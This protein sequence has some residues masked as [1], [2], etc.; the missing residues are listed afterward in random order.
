MNKRGISALIAT[1]LIV[2][3]TVAGVTLLW[4]GLN[5]LIQQI[6]FV[7]D[8]NLNFE[9]VKGKYT[10]FDSEEDLFSVR[11]SRGSDEANIV[12]MKFVLT[13]INGN[14]F[15]HTVDD[16][17]KPNSAKVY[18]F[19]IAT[20]GRVISANV[21]PIYDVDGEY[22]ESSLNENKDVTLSERDLDL[23]DD[24]VLFGLDGGSGDDDSSSVFDSGVVGYY[25][26]DS[27]SGTN[28]V[29]VSGNA[30][31]KVKKTITKLLASIISSFSNA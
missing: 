14:T 10:G 21:I 7:E 30:K 9:V 20:Y 15:D 26:F 17:P 4:V 19:S 5:P 13:D 3:L 18:S 16:I 6:A 22:R 31:Q 27:M 1:V 2:L 11:V 8:I 24:T 12:K 28:V 25:T 29:D 23:K